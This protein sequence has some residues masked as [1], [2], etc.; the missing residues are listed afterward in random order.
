[1]SA[2]ARIAPVLTAV[3][4]DPGAWLLGAAGFMVR[5]GIV[6]LVLPIWTAPSPVGIA[7]VIGPRIV[8]TERLDGPALSAALLGLAAIALLAAGALLA[9]AWLEAMAYERV[10]RDPEAE[11]LSRRQPGSVRRPRRLVRL[12]VVQLVALVPVLLAVLNGAGPIAASVRNEILLPSDLARPLVLRAAQ[13]AIE[14]L[15]LLALSIVAAEGINGLLSRRVLMP[16]GRADRRTTPAHLLRGMGGAIAASALG[17]LVTAVVLLPAIG[18]VVVAW[19]HVRVAWLS[20]APSVA[21][22]AG[23]ELAAIGAMLLFVVVWVG[24]LLLGGV[25]SAVRGALW[26]ARLLPEDGGWTTGGD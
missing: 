14:P 4:G 5:G 20:G 18:A 10:V 11:A 2:T 9:A 22:A 6:L 17:W 24:A 23:T 7:L 15:L 25:V 8:N 21:G 16:A 1:M 26:T 19:G 12:F 3:L 13:G